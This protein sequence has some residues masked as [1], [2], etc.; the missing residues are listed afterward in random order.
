MET[1]ILKNCRRTASIISNDPVQLLVIGKED[2]QRIFMGQTKT[3]EEPAHLKFCR[4]L[5]FLADWPVDLLLAHPETGVCQ[6]LLR[7]EITKPRLSGKREN[8]E[9]LSTADKLANLTEDRHRKTTYSASRVRRVPTRRNTPAEEEKRHSIEYGTAL[10]DFTGTAADELSFE[11]GDK[12][13][14][15]ERVNDDWLRGKHKGQEGMLP[16][17]FVELSKAESAPELQ[18]VKK[19]RKPTPKA[20][21]LFDFDGEF[22][23]ELSFKTGDVIVLVERVNEEW[24]K[25]EI[26][27]RVGRFPAAFVEILTPLP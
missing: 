12:I 24:F 9:Q 10:Y 18:S 14:I 23:D 17:T 26:N 16:R 6:V 20:K 7:L 5:D 27:K 2:Y 8:R 4:N 22:G 11:K 15:T 3:G 21:A 1:A 19:D 25:G 13:E